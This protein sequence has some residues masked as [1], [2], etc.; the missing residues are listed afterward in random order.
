MITV[1]RACQSQ[2]G[3]R[4]TFHPGGMTAISR[5]FPSVPSSAWDR[6]SPKLRFARVPVRVLPSQRLRPLPHKVVILQCS[7]RLV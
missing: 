5:W 7:C 4:V 2:A 1:Q 6:I 3:D